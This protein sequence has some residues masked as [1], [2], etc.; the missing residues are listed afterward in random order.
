MR[1]FARRR[2]SI[3]EQSPEIYAGQK[4][5]SAAKLA[6]RPDVEPRL[7]SPPPS[8]L[9]R[10]ECKSTF[11]TRYNLGVCLIEWEDVILAGSGAT[12]ELAMSE[13]VNACINLA[14]TSG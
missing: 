11:L 4:P 2:D 12:R 13:E 3:F 7:P 9:P 10:G 14:L 8:P 6:A 1:N 5:L